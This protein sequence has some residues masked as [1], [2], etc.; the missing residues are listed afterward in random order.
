VL[1]PFDCPQEGGVTKRFFSV[2]ASSLFAVGALAGPAAAADNG[3]AGPTL[4]FYSGGQGAQAHWQHD[5]NDSPDDD[6][7]QDIKIRTTTSP[8]G[9]AGVL[10]HHV[11]GTPVEAYPNSRFEVKTN[12]VA[13]SGVSSLGS[14]RLVI[15]FSDGGR[16][17]L[18]PLLLFPEWQTVQDPDW[19]NNGGTCGFLYET[20]WNVIQGCHAGAVVTNAYIA[21]DPYGF[22]YYIDNLETAGKTWSQAADNGNGGS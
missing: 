5:R 2:L 16:A 20:T 12:G 19:D 22:T 17:E 11:E 18:R 9:F 3:N 13:P 21:T 4:S 1:R 10:V 14:P 7:L 8:R 15:Q 6:N